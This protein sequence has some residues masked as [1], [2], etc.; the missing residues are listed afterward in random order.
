MILISWHVITFSWHKL[1]IVWHVITFSWRKLPI[2]WHVITF[3]WHDQSLTSDALFEPLA[4]MATLS[5][6]TRLY[7][8][9]DRIIWFGKGMKQIQYNRSESKL[10][11]HRPVRAMFT[12]DIRVA[13]TC[14]WLKKLQRQFVQEI[15]VLMD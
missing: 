11:D 9:C 1:P 14:K 5:L 6:T 3:S 2:V 10:S 7:C 15:L 12:A 4:A 8:R 13:G